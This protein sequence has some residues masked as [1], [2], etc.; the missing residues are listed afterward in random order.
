MNGLVNKKSIRKIKYSLA[1]MCP[2]LV[3]EWHP[4]KNDNLKPTDVT[5]GS[6]KKV[7][8]QCECG[9]EWQNS[10][11]DRVRNPQCPHCG[12]LNK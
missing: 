8:W 10:V 5:C 3:E 1:E 6:H 11:R 2:N 4:T 12:K 9:H 7:W